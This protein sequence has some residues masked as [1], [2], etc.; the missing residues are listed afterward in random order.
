MLRPRATLLLFA[1]TIFIGAALL[2]LL[3]LVFARLVLP[4]LGGAPA[5]WNT[6]MVFYQGLLL[7]G[8]A[9]AHFLS[10]RLRPKAQVMVHAGVLVAAFAFLPFALPSGLEVAGEG[11]PVR[12]LLGVLAVGVGLPFFA[13]SAT[14]PL[15]QKW[16]AGSGHPAA[17]DPYFLYAASNGGSLLGLLGYPLLVEPNSSLGVGVRGVCAAFGCLWKQ[18]MAGTAG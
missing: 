2:F 14:S 8:Y 11:S 6:A 10:S 13:V 16:F 15:L 5:V 17:G 3:Q 9:Y 1:L 18:G 7:A 4:L 12:W